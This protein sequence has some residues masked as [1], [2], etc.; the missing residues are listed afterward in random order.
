[1]IQA[2]STSY[3][4]KIEFGCGLINK[5]PEIIRRYGKNGLLVTGHRS[6]MAS[7]NWAKLEA[8]AAKLELNL[9]HLSVEEEPSPQLVDD[10]V[11]KFKNTDVDVVVGL[12]G[13]SALDAAKAIAGLLRIDHSVMDFLEGVGP[14]L[15]YTGPAVP[16]I[17]I[18]TTAGTGS[19]LTKNAVLSVRG[20]DGFKKSFRDEKLLAKEVIVDPELL[21][22]CPTG[23]IAAN[24]MDALTQL[25]ESYV[26]CRSNKF[27]DALALSG[28]DSVR[29]GLP[30]WY[31]NGGPNLEAQS[32]MAYGSMLSGITLAHVGLG[33]VHGLASPLGAFYPIPHG[34]VCG[35]LVA[36]AT[37]INID[38]MLKREPDNPAL[39]K[40]AHAAEVLTA[41]QYDSMESAQQALIDCLYEWK[42]LFELPGLARY[43]VQA[44]DLDYIVANSRG[45]SM[46]TNPI[47]LTDTEI[48]AVLTAC[49]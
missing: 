16:F 25:L 37:R 29:Q 15:A 22:T 33:S 30:S 1:M 44:D 35:T 9:L 8:H 14:E 27:T 13:G 20:K 40:Y 45:S 42:Q 17:A 48:T 36:D 2:F 21:S 4:P 6:F 49:L 18:P 10:A 12:G 43:G 32:H 46:K 47:V 28:L 24:G 5:V 7:N 39:Q 3:I 34:V 23:V 38:G 26:S 11:A 19:E 31:T 41:K